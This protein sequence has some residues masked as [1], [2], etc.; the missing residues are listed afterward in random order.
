MS[1]CTLPL[2]LTTFVYLLS[3]RAVCQSALSANSGINSSDTW[4]AVDV[5]VTSNT[6][7]TLPNPAYNPVTQTSSSTLTVGPPTLTFH[8]EAGYDSGG[9][10]VMNLWPTTAAVDPVNSDGNPLGFVRFAGGQM[11]AFDQSG[12]PLQ[13]PSFQGIPTNWPLNLLGSNPGPSVISNLVLP[14]VTAYA[15]TRSAALAYA[16]PAS[17]AYVTVPTTASGGAEW[18]FAQSGSNWVAKQVVL[19]PAISG[20]TSSRTVQFANL[21]WYDNAAND[22]ARASKGYTASPPP[23][24]PASM[25]SVTIGTPSG[26][27]TVSQF[28]GPQNVVFMHGMF[29]SGITWARM[30]NWANQDFRFGTEITPSFTASNS[31]SSQ[32]TALVNAINS[33][34]GSN[35]ILIGH[36]QGGLISRYA[37]QQYQ[38]ANSRQT[39]VAGVVTLDTPHEGADLIINA[40]IIS[41]DFAL[42]GIA[43]WDWTGCYTPFD[44]FVCLLSFLTKWGGVGFGAAVG[45]LPAL[46]PDMAD[47]TPGS[48]FLTQLNGYSETFKRAAVVGNTPQRWNESRVMWDFLAPYIFPPDPCDPNYYPESGCGERTVAAAVGVTYD[49]VEA[50]LF[51]SIFEQIFCMVREEEYCT[52]DYSTYIEYFAGI[53]V[54]MDGI[55]ALWNLIVSGYNGSDGIVQ[56][57]SQNYPSISAIQYPINGADSHLETTHSPYDHAT[58]DQVLQGSP[59]NVPTQ[60]S[61]TFAPAP[62]TYSI[63]GVG[64]TSSFSLGTG[65]GCQWSAVSQQPWLSITSGTSGQSSGTVSFSVAANPVTNPRAGTIQVGSG[66]SMSNFAVYQAGAC[67]YSL[68]E[69][70]VVAVPPSGESNTVTVTTTSDCVW[71]AVSNANWLTIS[72]GA[73]GTGTGSFTYTAAPNSGSVDLSGTITVMNQALTVIVGSPVGTPGSGTVTI[74][75]GPASVTFNPCQNNVYPAPNYCPQT[76]YEGGDVAVTVGS[77]TYTTGYGEGTTAAQIAS[78]LASQMNYALSPI[79]ATVSGTTITIRSIVNGAATNYS[80]STSYQYDTT[81]FSSP[82][83]TGA[84]SGTSLT[85]GTN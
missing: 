72:S 69:G 79:F 60:A 39:T 43:L 66:L 27:T 37:A 71:S 57:A 11:T 40:P 80:L 25:P 3:A 7:I 23:T 1:R 54:G 32:G 68:S 74:N 28:G 6:S 9:G 75:G 70:P 84:A 15:S 29:S 52:D 85:G 49:V 19:T 16:S 4:V 35:Y 46:K 64:G 30:E 41:P 82:A 59:F 31:L 12:N 77:Q 61:C 45:V 56:S 51:F 81:D 14:S 38:I 8:V 17:T 76:I 73:S 20:G 5:T 58:L 53:L 33:A 18:T 34:G 10:L 55:D 62:S 63:S 65:T 21:S 24:S 36:S 44:N 26:S 42:L 48:A 78:A 50:L 13:M 2:L 47:L 67:Y 22:S 83:F